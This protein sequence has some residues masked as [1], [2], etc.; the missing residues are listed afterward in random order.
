VRA[1]FIENATLAD[2][3]RGR[4]RTARDTPMEDD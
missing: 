4:R 1:I 3:L 2:L